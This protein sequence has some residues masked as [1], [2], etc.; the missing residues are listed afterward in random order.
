MTVWFTSDSHFGHEKIIVHCKRPFSS[1]EEMDE[2][3]IRR[4]N[5]RVAPDDTVYHLGDFAMK[6]ATAA[7]YASRLHGKKVLVSGNHD[8]SFIKHQKSARSVR[9]YVEMGFAEVHRHTTVVT[10]PALGPVMLS[11]LPIAGDSRDEH[12]RYPEFRPKALAPGCKYLFHGH[13]HERWKRQGCMLNVGVDVWDFRPVS[14][15][16][17]Q[18]YLERSDD[19]Q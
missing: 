3:M 9:R 19:E 7:A 16:E 2:E 11:H 17:L 14:V 10:L 13:V 18:A 8:G 4:F 1:A 15:Q 6:E 12:D 5:E